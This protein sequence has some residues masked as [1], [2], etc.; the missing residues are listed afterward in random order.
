VEGGA[1]VVFPCPGPSPRFRKNERG[2]GD[3][4]LILRS[5]FACVA[6]FVLQGTEE[7]KQS[8]RRQAQPALCIIPWGRNP[9]RCTNATPSPNTVRSE[10]IT[11][12]SP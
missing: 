10:I 11:V 12:I 5:F 4:M 7:L 8:D 6:R 1:R 3:V 2:V 9:L